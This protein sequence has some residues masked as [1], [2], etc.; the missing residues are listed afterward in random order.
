MIIVSIHSILFQKAARQTDMT[1]RRNNKITMITVSIHKFSIASLLV[2][3]L[4]AAMFSI[5]RY[6]A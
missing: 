2:L 4:T 1:P 5:K 6:F 3:L